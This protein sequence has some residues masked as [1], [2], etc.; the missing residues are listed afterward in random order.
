MDKI[1]NNVSI[2]KEKAEQELQY[3]IDNNN[4]EALLSCMIAQLLLISPQEG[5][6]DNYG[7]HPVMLEALAKKCIPKFGENKS[8]I[9][10]PMLTNHCYGL[11]EA[12]IRGNMFENLQAKNDDKNTSPNIIPLLAM[13]SKIVRGSAYPEQTYNKIKVIQ[14]SFDNW[15]EKK[16]GISPN[17][18]VDLILALIK[19]VESIASDDLVLYRESGSAWQSRYNII[20]KKNKKTKKEQRFIDTFPKGKDG[21]MAAFCCGYSAMQNELMS[22][23]L[24]TELSTLD[25]SPRLT[26]KEIIS[27][28]NLFCINKNSI[29]S[30]EYIQRK[31]FYELTSGK[32][33]FSEISNC[34]DVIWDEYEKIAKSD[35]KFYSSRYQK[36]KSNWLEEQIY[37]HLSTIFPKD[38]IYKNLTYQDPTK[39]N[40][41]AELDLAVK[42]GP[43]LLVIEAK[44]KQF[45]FESVNGDSGRL[46]TDIKNN[47]QDAYNQSLR[48]IQYIENNT[49]CKFVE[50]D[51]KK[52]L[53]FKSDSLHC[54]F[55]ISVSFH[56]LA[57]IAT[58]L[59]EL[60]E[61]GL[62][63]ENKYPFSICES[64][65]ELLTYTK[66]S[67]DSFLHYISRRLYLLESDTQWHGDEIDM[68]LAY[69][70]CRLLLPNIINKEIDVPNRLSFSCYSAKMDQLMSFRRGEYP[71]KP[72]I[73]LQL[74]S[75]VEP[76]FEH[77]K[78]WNDDGARW[79]SFALLELDN[80]TL[81]RIGQLLNELKKTNIHHNGF[82]RITFHHGNT[83]ISIVGS[84]V[85]SFEEL[86]QNTRMRGLIEKYRSHKLKSIVFGVLSNGNDKIF[87]YADYIEFE[88]YKDLEM[89]EVIDKEPIFIPS[90][91]PNRNEICFCG[92]GKKY[93]KCCLNKVDKARKTHSYLM[94]QQYK[95]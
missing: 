88:W 2:E 55:P 76:I 46:R 38:F 59:D 65:L 11:L 9:I 20:I 70:D 39:E 32:I 95:K 4:A 44:A 82:R 71:Y 73:K 14:G 53:I 60:K 6:G 81:Y 33:I 17:R 43:F 18:T 57:G 83:V 15:F 90:K 49:E 16:V 48:T 51:T 94:P 74:P 61:L 54:I 80:K 1:P 69:L 45:R 85:A 27:F 40:G 79:I 10:S 24:P 84:K 58:Q 64:D 35:S 21:E 23:K 47:I 68:V 77:L 52:E 50:I 66:L 62:F 7:S 34:F 92:S 30:I 42:W 36:K 63:I 8:L 87:D 26:E 22:E 56:H 28:K 89:E 12:I 86:K 3:L 67:P 75:G 91:E 31:T 41:T 19:R 29:S 93:K 78:S 37:L 72:D 5:F 25:L 13:R